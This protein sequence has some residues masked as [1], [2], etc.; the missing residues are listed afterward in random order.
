VGQ[1]RETNELLLGVRYGMDRWHKR[2][3]KL[4]DGGY[5]YTDWN[6]TGI[7]SELCVCVTGYRYATSDWD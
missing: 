7:N 6:A 5:K 2:Q 3:T 4:D 1:G